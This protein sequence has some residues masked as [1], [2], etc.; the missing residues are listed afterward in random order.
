MKNPSACCSSF[1]YWFEQHFT[2]C[3]SSIVYQNS[4]INPLILNILCGELLLNDNFT[5]SS[6]FNSCHINIYTYTYI[7]VQITVLRAADSRFTTRA[8][9]K[10]SQQ[11]KKLL[12]RLFLREQSLIYWAWYSS[13][14]RRKTMSSFNS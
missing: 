5:Q 12:S 11:L 10:G 1:L 8:A 6:I 13:V 4:P 14:A 9:D 3:I 2:A 7:Y